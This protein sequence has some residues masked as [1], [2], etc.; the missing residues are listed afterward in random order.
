MEKK[1]EKRKSFHQKPSFWQFELLSSEHKVNQDNQDIQTEVY[2]W[3]LLINF[4][5]R[6]RHYPFLETHK[7]VN[8]YSM[9]KR[10][11]TIVLHLIHKRLCSTLDTDVVELSTNDSFSLH[12]SPSVAQVS[13]AFKLNTLQ[14]AA[15]T[16]IAN[17]QIFKEVYIIYHTFLYTIPL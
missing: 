14:S 8:T 13:T 6:K 5:K 1:T 9:A 10:S 7:Y 16:K 2:W 3:K 15:F 11:N 4:L 12:V 17:H